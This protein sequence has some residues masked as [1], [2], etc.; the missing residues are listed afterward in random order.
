MQR[1]ADRTAAYPVLGGQQV[2]ISSTYYSDAEMQSV[3]NVL[4]GLAHGEEM[5]TLSAYLASPEELSGIC[6]PEALA[7]YAPAIGLMIVSGVDGFSYGVPRD[8]TIAHEYGHHIANNRINAP[9]AALD[10]GAK[11]WATYERVCQGIRRNQLHPGDEGDNYWD[12]PG[13]A[14][15]E[16]N[17]RLNFPGTLVPWG[18]NAMLR[19]NQVSL[20]KLAAD[21]AYPWTAPSSVTWNGSLWR[22]RENP[23]QR[24]FKT[25]LDGEVQITLDGP[26]G[27]NYDLYVLGRKLRPAKADRKAEKRGSKHR[28]HR[29]ARKVRRRV[30]TRAASA[31]SS[32]Q[33]TMNL[34]GQE[35]VRV[36]VRRRAGSGPF[37]VTVT[38]P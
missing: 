20:A 19:P 24:R 28:R 29:K 33:L 2:E 11:R 16:A 38:R 6:G 37:S 10:S 4:G 15:A 14:F 17:A 30:I 1:A 32:E 13:E 34:C 35:A 12:N 3:A 22:Q 7:C 9:W 27:S 26:D 36:E 18:Y 8:Y 21:I 31:G 23:A 5:N 25:P